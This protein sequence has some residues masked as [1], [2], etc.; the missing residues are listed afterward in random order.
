MNSEDINSTE[1]EIVNVQHPIVVQNTTATL[2]LKLDPEVNDGKLNL[3][4]IALKCRN[5]EYNP[6]RFSGKKI[7]LSFFLAY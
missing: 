6:K 2:T 4:E 3:A 7:D 5:S 1:P